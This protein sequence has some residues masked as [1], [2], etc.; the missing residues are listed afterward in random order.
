MEELKQKVRVF[1]NDY[2]CGSKFVKEELGT[3]DFFVKLRKER[4]S[5]E[6][7]TL[8][9][10]SS[11]GVQGKK[12]LEVGCGLGT[13]GRQ[14]AENGAD[15]F[16]VDLA[17]R[18]I[19]LAKKAFE[20]FGLK[21]N[22]RVADA[23][24]LP[25]DDNSFD[26]VY[27]HGVLH[28]TPDTQKAIDDIYRVLKPGGKAIIMLYHRNSYNYYINIMFIRRIG[29]FL[30]Y[31]PGGIKLINKVTKEDPQRLLEHK[32]NLISEGLEY[33]SAQRFLTQNTDG[34]G[35][36]LSKVYTKKQAANMFIKFSNF[37]TDV[38]YLNKRWLPLIGKYLPYSIE[39]RL[40]R[41]WG[42]HLYIFATK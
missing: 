35:N 24:N 30:L 13:D 1:W 9:I 12:V 3:K 28:H 25:F 23:E 34:P 29:V 22:F 38:K 33:L 17:P 39:A 26:L 2:P 20:L 32:T 8:E 14:F 11:L 40:S 31:L 6:P 4:Y 19:E 42:W 41:L 36:P 5:L 18:H 16:A 10:I 15:Y 37:T 21:G 27:S 7:H